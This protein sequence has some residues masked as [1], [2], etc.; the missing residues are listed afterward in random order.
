MVGPAI[1]RFLATLAV[2]AASRHSTNKDLIEMLRLG[3]AVARAGSI[4][5]ERWEDLADRVQTLVDEDRPPTVDEL[6]ALRVVRS[7]MED[8]ALRVQLPPREPAD[9]QPDTLTTVASESP[10]PAMVPAA[11]GG[12]AAAQTDEPPQSP[13]A[14]A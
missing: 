12:S 13:E 4:G 9:P 1:S 3:A 8:R 11:A 14:S 6:N 2:Y 7:E 5:R 10:P